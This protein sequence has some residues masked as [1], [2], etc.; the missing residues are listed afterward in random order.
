MKGRIHIYKVSE[1]IKYFPNNILVASHK[2][3][4]SKCDNKYD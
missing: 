1:K 4:F 2:I 3:I